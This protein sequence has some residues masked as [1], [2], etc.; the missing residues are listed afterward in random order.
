MPLLNDSEYNRHCQ[1]VRHREKERLFLALRRPQDHSAIILDESSV[2]TGQHCFAEE[3]KDSLYQG[4]NEEESIPVQVE[5]DQEEKAQRSEFGDLRDRE[6]DFHAFPC[7]NESSSDANV[8]FPFKDKTE[9]ILSTLLS[10]PDR[11][12][13]GFLEYL[14]K[15]MKLIGV[16]LPSLKN[17]QKS[18]SKISSKL[19]I[20][21]SITESGSIFYYIPPSN[22]LSQLFSTIRI[23]E[24]MLLYPDSGKTLN[25]ISQGGKIFDNFEL[26]T[27]MLNLNGMRI[28]QNDIIQ[29]TNRCS[30]AK[31]HVLVRGFFM[32]SD[33]YFL[34]GFSFSESDGIV[35]LTNLIELS[36]VEYDFEVLQERLQI[37]GLVS[38]QE[39]DRNMEWKIIDALQAQ[40]PL[41]ER[42]V[43]EGL[44]V[45]AVHFTLFSDDTS[46]NKSKKWNKVDVVYL[47]LSSKTNSIF[48]VCI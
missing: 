34:K 31:G 45:F 23:R 27:P 4:L 8:W 44:D 36:T 38:E 42:S 40:H 30:E 43:R 35:D 19:K 17:L 5:E 2:N 20:E 26:Q 41:K 32:R 28:F 29:I 48:A 10:H 47:R 21:E 7:T 14:W 39:V 25:C 24:K 3:V 12:S 11:P 46:A 6:S 9:V 37:R 1:S 16:H 18:L 22:I 33:I 13:K 15:I